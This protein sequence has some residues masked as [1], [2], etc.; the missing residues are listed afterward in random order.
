M[1]ERDREREQALCEKGCDR[2][3]HRHCRHQLRRHSGGGIL[4][5]TVPNFLK[6]LLLP[7]KNKNDKDG[8][9]ERQLNAEPPAV[10]ICLSF[11]TTACGCLHVPAEPPPHSPPLEESVIYCTHG[12]ACS[13]FGAKCRATYPPATSRA[14][15]RDSS[16]R[17]DWRQKSACIDESGKCIQEKKTSVVFKRP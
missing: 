14:V 12:T 9:V 4:S 15:G 3:S 17:L 6:L 5:C 8:D 10:Y 11:Y 13:N 16:T 2:G 1:R 7:A